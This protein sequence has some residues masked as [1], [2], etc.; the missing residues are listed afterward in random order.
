MSVV[1]YENRFKEMYKEIEVGEQFRNE[2]IEHVIKTFHPDKK[3]KGQIEYLVRKPK[4]PFNSIC[5][6]VKEVDSMVEKSVSLKTCI[7]N[8][9]GLYKETKELDKQ[10]TSAYRNVINDGTYFV[11]RIENTNIIEGKK[12]GF[13]KECKEHTTEP[14]I[15]HYPL[16]FKKILEDYLKKS[17]KKLCNTIINYEDD[18]LCYITYIKDRKEWL[19]Y[20]D[21]VAQYRVLCK[22][23][24]CSRGSYGY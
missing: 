14:Q 15:D 4:P 13:C 24:N 19:T 9:L 7:R 18:G 22:K 2:E 17:K 16:P 11:Y 10:I 5:F 8:L 21:S 1:F 12:E 20:H 3:I 23:C 6:F